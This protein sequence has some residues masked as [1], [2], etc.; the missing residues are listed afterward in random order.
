MKASTS[1]YGPTRI[2]PTLEA[3]AASLWTFVKAKAPNFTMNGARDV[4]RQLNLQPGEALNSVA[5]R[6]MVVLKTHRIKLKHIPALHA[7]AG[8][9]GFDSLHTYQNDDVRRLVFSAFD[10][11]QVKDSQFDSWD[12]L[13]DDLR[14]WVDR[15]R[16]RGQLPLGVLKLGFTVGVISF[17]TPV[18]SAKGEVQQRPQD[19]PLAVITSGVDDPQWLDGAP[20]ALAKLRRHLEENGHAVLDGY[21]ALRLCANSQDIPGHPTAVTVKD[22][23]N[24]EL[25][26]MREDDE[27]DPHSGYEIARGDE[28]SCW[29]QLEL[30]MRD[31]ESNEMP[32]LHITVPKDGVGAW[33]VNGIRYVWSV[34]TLKPDAY[35]PGRVTRQISVADCDRLQGRYHLAKRIHGKSFKHREHSK[36]LD[37]LNGL[38]DAYR[39]DLHFV[40]HELNKAGLTWDS[41]IEKFEL[42]PVPMANVLPVGF[43]F[44]FLENLQVDKPNM[45]FAKPNVSEMVRVGDDGLLR[46]LM[47]R[48]DKVVYVVPAGLDEQH[49]T[50]LR[51]VVDEFASGLHAQKLFTDAGGLRSER[52]LPHLVWATEAEE[53]RLGVGALGLAIR[54]ATIP[55]LHST[56]GIIPEIPGVKAWPWASGNAL[57]LRFE[58]VGGAQ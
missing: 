9:Y 36:R 57:F 3:Q 19:W 14:K 47:Q 29:Y 56:K 11:G 28:L 23:V 25:V 45:V 5:K 55:Y 13:A 4:I 17:T 31:D 12:Q 37:Y 2:L 44:Q 30:S 39:I 27:D 46:A 32:T 24:S 34:E 1:A 20:A 50:A 52:E 7:A 49:A 41:Y 53:F 15:L 18:P 35:V 8:L 51:E 16:A 21:E 22:V 33:Y 6:L 38:P 26:L 58:R 48:V 54:A 43:V 10:T 42:E 40:L